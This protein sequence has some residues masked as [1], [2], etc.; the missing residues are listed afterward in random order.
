MRRTI[1]WAVVCI[2]LLSIISGGCKNPLLSGAILHFDQGRYERAHETLLK[3]IEQEPQNAEAHFWLG[4]TYAELD[5]TYLARQYLD[6]AA[7]LAG[8]RHPEMA[9]SANEALAHYWSRHHNN[10]LSA[11]T[12]AQKAKNEGKPDEA[13]EGFRTSLGQFQRARIYGPDKEETPRNM[14]AVYFNLG[15]VDSG[16]VALKDS[17]KLADPGD[18]R[19]ANQLFE[20]YRFLGD[21]AGLRRTDDGERDP[22]GL[23]DAVKFYSEA[24][25][26]RPNDPDLLFSIGVVYYQLAE[27]DEALRIERM[28]KAA[29]YFEKTLAVNPDDQEALYNAASLHLELETCDKGLP[30]A[31]HLLDL[32]PRQGRYHD[33]V[34]RI[35][36]CLGEKTVRLA[37]LVFSRALRSGDVVPAAEFKTHRE[38]WGPQSD[39]MRKHREAG[40]PEEIRTFTDAH[41]GKYVTWFYWT[42]GTAYAFYNGDEKYETNFKPQQP[43]DESGT[44]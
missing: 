22:E 24:E 28:T 19:A 10:G 8:E 16:L 7:E 30:L 13:A 32:D 12:G 29:E 17:Q 40:E 2:G 38:E 37:G 26:L 11:A 36:D 34:G 27:T 6:K 43:E 42:R 18:E 15:L 25:A 3:A 44:E 5:S 31:T 23:K 4:K 9:V 14:G 39:L 35:N 21:Q 20:Q 33:L 1:T 41:G